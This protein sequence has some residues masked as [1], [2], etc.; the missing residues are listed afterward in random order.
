MTSITSLIVSFNKQTWGNGV[1][2]F[3]LGTCACGWCVLAPVYTM[4]AQQI[5]AFTGYFIAQLH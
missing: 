5:P 3:N 4:P 2:T 1:F